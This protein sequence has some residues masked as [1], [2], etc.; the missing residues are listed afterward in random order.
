VSELAEL[1]NEQKLI[2]ELV[3]SAKRYVL[4]FSINKNAIISG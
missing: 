1:T 2:T 4:P 3:E